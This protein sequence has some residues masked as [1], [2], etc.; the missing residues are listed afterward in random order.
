MSLQRQHFLL[1]YL[2]TLSVGPA[3]V[4]THDLPHGSPVLNQLSQPV[5]RTFVSTHKKVHNKAPDQVLPYSDNTFFINKAANSDHS[6]AAQPNCSENRFIEKTNQYHT[7][8]FGILHETICHI[9]PLESNTLKDLVRKCLSVLSSISY[10]SSIG[11]G[12]TSASF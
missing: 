10:P 6:R 1:S 9:W 4:R 12:V 3:G 5:G 2:K 11:D 8:C 7:C